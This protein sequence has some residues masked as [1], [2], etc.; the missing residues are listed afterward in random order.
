LN[1]I[2]IKENLT[3]EHVFIFKP[4]NNSITNHIY[5]P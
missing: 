5:F 3:Y 1:I 4:Y 2:I